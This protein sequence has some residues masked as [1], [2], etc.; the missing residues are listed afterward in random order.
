MTRGQRDP[1]WCETLA[2]PGAG[3]LVDTDRHMTL[4]EHELLNFLETAGMVTL[5]TSLAELAPKLHQSLCGPREHREG[6]RLLVK[7]LE[8]IRS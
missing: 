2:D 4:V 5:P 8:S 7:L 3:S 1:L 6:P